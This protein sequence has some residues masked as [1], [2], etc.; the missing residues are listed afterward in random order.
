MKLVVEK[1]VSWNPIFLALVKDPVYPLQTF[2]KCK[3]G[4]VIFEVILFFSGFY[5]RLIDLPVADYG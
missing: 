3:K 4:S 2:K 1:N 5:L